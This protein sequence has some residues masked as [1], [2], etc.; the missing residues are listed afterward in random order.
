MT[1]RTCRALIVVLASLLA[2][3]ETAKTSNP[4]SPS[5][6][7]PIPG[8]TISSPKPLEPG[9]GWLLERPQ[10]PLTLLVE[11]AA[12]NGQRPLTYTLR[13][14][15]MRRSPVSCTRANQC[16]RATA[17]GQVSGCLMRW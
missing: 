16:R 8:V 5:V 12:S 17:G 10:Q 15:P 14:R 13:S 3:C 1:E 6:A 11:N 4:L 7:G 2:G 9:N